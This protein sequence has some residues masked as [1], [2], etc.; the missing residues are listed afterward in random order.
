MAENKGPKTW[1]IA[2]VYT[3]VAL[4]ILVNYVSKQ[5][6]TRVQRL[7]TQETP[8]SAE[9]AGIV[10]GPTPAGEGSGL[11]KK[12][13]DEQ[14]RVNREM[15]TMIEQ[16]QAS[17]SG[18][19]VDSPLTFSRSGEPTTV[20]IIP[21]IRFRDDPGSCPV[22][23]VKSEKNPFLPFYKGGQSAGLPRLPRKDDG[24]SLRPDPKIPMIFF[25]SWT[26]AT[27]LEGPAF[28]R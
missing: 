10:D 26:K 8:T 1:L 3:I 19:P 13:L 11:L 21:P 25:N 6:E 20:G 18:T 12:Q 2:I 15:Q 17:L 7:Q 24:F 28:F 5:S 27:V 4:T 14:R 23:L 9:E 16:M 22:S